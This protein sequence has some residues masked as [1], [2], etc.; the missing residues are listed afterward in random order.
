MRQLRDD[1]SHQQNDRSNTGVGHQVI[2]FQ[3]SVSRHTGQSEPGGGDDDPNAGHGGNQSHHVHEE[4]SVT[5]V[6][7]MHLFARL[8]A[9]L[10][11][12]T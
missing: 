9:L 10:G 6:H 11:P 4:D 2:S 3:P 8:K 7:V 5:T 1:L 12:G